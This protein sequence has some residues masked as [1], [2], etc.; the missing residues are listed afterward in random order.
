MITTLLS[1]LPIMFLIAM[2]LLLRSR[3]LID[4]GF[5]LPCEKL[6]YFYLFPALMFAQVGKTALSQFA[7]Q[8]IAWSIL[9]AV[10][11]GG[12]NTLA[13]ATV[14]KTARPDVLFRDPRVLCVPI[15]ISG[16]PQQ[17]PT[18]IPD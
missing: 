17:Q 10:F 9:G 18:D 4:I 6:N 2:G 3:N 7:V 11:I 15:P 1:L 16:L 14:V 8:P 5:W 12:G 13:V